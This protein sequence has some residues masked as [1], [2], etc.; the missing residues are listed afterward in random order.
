MLGPLAMAAGE[1]SRIKADWQ[2]ATRQT[3]GLA[4]PAATTQEAV[5]QIYAARAF[6]WRGVFAVHTWI[7]LKPEGAT[8]YT[9]YEVMGWHVF[10]AAMRCRS[11][12]AGPIATG[13]ATSQ[14]CSPMCAVTRQPRP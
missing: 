2:T 1:E 6:A 10:G 9:T 4:P 3:A 7:S 8:E 14:N 13:S 11:T 12:M 5:V